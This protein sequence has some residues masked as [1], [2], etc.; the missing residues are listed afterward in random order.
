[1]PDLNTDQKRMKT[2]HAASLSSDDCGVALSNGQS[3]IFDDDWNQTGTQNTLALHEFPG[4]RS[5]LGYTLQEDCAMGHIGLLNNSL[6]LGGQGNRGGF[7]LETYGIVSTSPDASEE[8]NNS[9][10]SSALETNVVISECDNA[11][12]M[13]LSL[14]SDLH[15]KLETLKKRPQQQREEPK[16]LDCYPIGSVLHLLQKLTNIASAISPGVDISM[17]LILLSCYITMI[18]I[19]ILVLSDFQSY[20]SSQPDSPACTRAKPGPQVC[21]GE[22]PSTNPPH[23]RIYTAVCLLLESL[24]QAEEALG[25]P[26]QNWVGDGVEPKEKGNT[27]IDKAFSN[28][29]TEQETTSDYWE[30]LTRVNSIQELF[31]TTF[32]K[33]VEDIKEL[34]REKMGL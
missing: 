12:A 2:K 11:I 23:S 5:A 31:I 3:F 33:K 18:Q 19:C 28:A 32:A 22:L 20:L 10:H 8:N 6:G 4:P 34:L 21:L 1:M 9:G 16:S 14:A 7:A 27:P 24:R 25:L 29:S 15:A 17:A 13:L 26:P 30:L